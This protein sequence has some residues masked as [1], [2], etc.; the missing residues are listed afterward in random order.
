VPLCHLYYINTLL[1]IFKTSDV[2]INLAWKS[3]ESGLWQN[4]SCMCKTHLGFRRFCS[5]LTIFTVLVL[6]GW[7]ST[8]I[9]LPYTH[10]AIQIHSILQHIIIQLH[11]NVLRSKRSLHTSTLKI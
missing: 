5:L 11:L 3:K 1:T 10:N 6:T 4:L 8:Q 9:N 2:D 7:P